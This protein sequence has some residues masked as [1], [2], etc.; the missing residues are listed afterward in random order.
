MNTQQSEFDCV[1]AGGHDPFDSGLPGVH[2]AACPSV[3][4]PE[5]VKFLA[6]MLF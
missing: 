1:R 4:L 3:R 6:G 2:C 5:A